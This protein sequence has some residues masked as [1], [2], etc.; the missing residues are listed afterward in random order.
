ML[1]KQWGEWGLGGHSYEQH[2]RSLPLLAIGSD[3]GWTDDGQTLATAPNGY[4]V[5]WGKKSAG[6]MLDG[7]KHD[8]FPLSPHLGLADP[9][10]WEP[11]VGSVAALAR[12]NAGI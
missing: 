4:M 11:E 5:R 6:R 2:S 1:F 9:V 3:G 7:V 8:G 12:A 10:A